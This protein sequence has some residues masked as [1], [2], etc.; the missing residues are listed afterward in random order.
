M[1]A[2]SASPIDK[3]KSLIKE[4]LK[5]SMNDYSSY[6]PV[7][8]GKMD[9]VYTNLETDSTFIMIDVAYESYKEQQKKN[10]DEYLADITTGDKEL[11][12]IDKKQNDIY[13]GKID[14]IGKLRAK[15]LSTFK[16][17]FKG[18]RLEHTFRGKNKLGAL[19]VNKYAFYFDKGITKILD[20]QS[21]DKE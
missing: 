10:L 12:G 21:L 17:D 7:D 6:E 19:V 9:S 20:S 1:F 2:C 4:E 11:M 3:A 18:W 5:K 13:A 14:S 16:P 15:V 8:F